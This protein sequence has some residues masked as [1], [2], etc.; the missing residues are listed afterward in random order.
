MTC[1]S[2][3]NGLNRRD[4]ISLAAAATLV[5]GAASLGVAPE[6]K[7]Q[8]LAM[9][10]LP[11][12]QNALEPYIS[13]NTVSFHYGKHTKAYY[14]NTA[15][16][17]EGKPLAGQPLDKVFLEAAKDPAQSALF[18][19]A[20]QAFNHTFYWNCLVPGGKQPSG[21]LAELI[22]S[23]FGGP[24]NLKKEFAEAAVTVFGS[25]WAWLVLE[26]AKLKIVKTANAGNPLQNGQKP[27]LTIDVWEH[28]YYLDYQN[29][30]AD[31]VK[32]ILDNLANWDFA[33]KNLG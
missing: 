11:Y 14:D 13:A 8:G 9:P 25:G 20:A 17:L 2:D 16:M 3:K 28:A 7:A 1:P 26:D 32:A 21:K 4:F 5:A 22:G 15:K 33:A 12:P 30:R 27:L 29:R 10:E 19:N 23:S 24:D 18:N 6:A 31:Y